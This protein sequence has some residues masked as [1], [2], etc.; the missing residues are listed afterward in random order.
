MYWPKSSSGSLIKRKTAPQARTAKAVAGPRNHLYAELRAPWGRP[1]HQ[2]K[3][4]ARTIPSIKFLCADRSAHVP[5]DGTS[6]AEGRWRAGWG[7]LNANETK[8]TRTNAH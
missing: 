5:S 2:G 3:E 6:D 1:R 8:P 7:E 4:F